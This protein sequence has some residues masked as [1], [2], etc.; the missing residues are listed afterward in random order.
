V[1]QILLAGERGD[2]GLRR[3]ETAL[4]ARG[5]EIVE[6]EASGEIDFILTAERIEKVVFDA[7]RHEVLC[8]QRL[9]RRHAGRTWIPWTPG[10]SSAR[11]A[12]LLQAGAADVLNGAMADTELVARVETA[13]PRD[14]H[15]ADELLVGAL[16]I[17]RQTGEVT[18][19]GQD[20]ELTRREREVLEILAESAGRAVRRETL[21]KDVWGFAM[22]RG[23]RTVDVNVKRLRDKLAAAGASVQIK[24]R[25]GIGY[26]LEPDTASVVDEALV[27]EL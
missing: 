5:W 13:R 21:Y 11:T 22:A 23:D 17:D 3:L 7:G 10:Y 26:R 16:R 1:A 9:R 14:R 27:T 24:T 8:L 19:E 2:P 6:T 4:A 25:P 20:L 15:E 18:L 12:E